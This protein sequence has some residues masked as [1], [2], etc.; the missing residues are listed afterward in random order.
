MPEPFGRLTN[1]AVPLF[2]AMAGSLFLKTIS[3]E[4]DFKAV[5]FKKTKRILIPYFIWA[6]VYWIA[7]SIVFDVVVKHEPLCIPGIRSWL[8]GGTACH[9]WFLP[10]L[11]LAFAVFTLGRVT[12]GHI[13]HQENST[14]STRLKMIAFEVTILAFATLSQFFHDSTSAT[15]TGYVKIYLGRLFFYFAIGSLLMH[16]EV[17]NTV[18]ARIIGL[19]ICLIGGANIVYGWIVGLLWNPLVLVVGL[20]IL[21]QSVP[22]IKIPYWIEKLA[23]ASM[24]IYLIHVLFTSGA[25]FV[26]Q[27][28][29]MIPLHGLMGL[30]LSIILFGVTY[31]T[32]RILPR[33]V[34]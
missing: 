19:G 8:L 1:V 28:A 3:G 14:Q 9:L 31:L 25:N 15:F 34:F 2:A 4:F 32:V 26:L 33:K 6:I 18:I 24:G 30:L 12:I 7:N 23:D 20:L 11:F 27:K 13:E 21:A 16:I 29:G 17:P 5:L 10:C 22:H